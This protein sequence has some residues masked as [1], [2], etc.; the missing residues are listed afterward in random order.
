M[1]FAEE[2]PPMCPPNDAIDAAYPKI[3]RLLRQKPPTAVNFYSH[4]KLGKI[5]PEHVDGC[6]WASCSLVLDP[7]KLK[8]L[9]RFKKHHYAAVLHI[10]KGAGYSKKTNQ[11]HVEFWCNAEFVMLNS[12]VDVVDI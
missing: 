11:N 12:V 10:P 6:L 1:P 8:K 9:P 2:L 3:Y 7:F 5:C 4:A